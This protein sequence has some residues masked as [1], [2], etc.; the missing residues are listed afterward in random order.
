MKRNIVAM[1]I[2]FTM[3]GCAMSH[4]EFADPS[5][6]SI[7]KQPI[8]VINCKTNVKYPLR[9]DIFS[10]N[11][12]GGYELN[13]ITREKFNNHY[14]AYNL[15]KDC[16]KQLPFKHKMVEFVYADKCIVLRLDND[17]R[18]WAAHYTI[19]ITGETYGE[20]FG[21][22]WRSNQALSKNIC[23]RNL[24]ISRSKKRILCVDR[25]LL[26]G[27]AIAIVYV[28]QADKKSYPFP[29]LY[30]WDITQPESLPYTGRILD[31][32]ADITKSIMATN[33]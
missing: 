20:L 1:L 8:Q 22:K 23:W 27:N 11:Y 5:A 18:T 19:N 32:F 2:V 28:L 4:F 10:P 9:E 29:T 6:L 25:I 26:D 17:Y 3:T 21:E 24:I 33:E 30:H 12:T 13:F 15:I 16:I 31:A 7:S 14:V